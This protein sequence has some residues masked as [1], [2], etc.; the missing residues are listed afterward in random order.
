MPVSRFRDTS[1]P[2]IRWFKEANAAFDANDKEIPPPSAESEAGDAKRWFDRSIGI[3]EK[4]VSALG[5]VGDPPVE[6]KEAHNNYFTAVSELLALNRRMSD[7]LA[8]AGSDFNMAQ[9]ANDPE[10]GTAPQGR[11]WDLQD[12]ACGELTLIARESVVGA[13][14]GCNLWY[15]YGGQ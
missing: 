8:D 10:L 2:L 5:G 1:T 11:L 3:Q 6:L 14:L 7:R 9:L 13:R 12:K 15:R 4:L